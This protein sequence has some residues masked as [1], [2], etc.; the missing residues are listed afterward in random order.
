MQGLGDNK[1][2]TATLDAQ[3]NARW[4]AV[5]LAVCAATILGMILL[6][7]VTRLTES[8]LSMVDWRPIMGVIPPLTEAQWLATFAEY[9]QYP[10]YQKINQG[11]DLAGFKQIFWFEYLHR[12]LGRLIGLMYFIPLVIFLA[13][14]MI[15]K[16]LIP[17][18]MILLMEARIN[19]LVLCH[20]LVLDRRLLMI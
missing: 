18:L 8:G 9:Q 5:W 13:Y 16:R 20:P 3:V 1:M 2:T 11:M 15:A 7:G 6:G 14:R 12:M 10:E 4:I 19:K 17:I